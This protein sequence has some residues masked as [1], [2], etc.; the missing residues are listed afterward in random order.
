VAYWEDLT[1]KE[2]SDVFEVSENHVK[3]LLFRARQRFKGVAMATGKE[4][5]DGLQGM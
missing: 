3:V 4:K 2:I 1:L 5:E